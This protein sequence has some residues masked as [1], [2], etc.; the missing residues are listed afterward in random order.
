M[1][2]LCFEGCRLRV[3]ITYEYAG[4]SG[5]PHL[6][7]ICSTET[8]FYGVYCSLP[9]IYEY[10]LAFMP[11]LRTFYSNKEKSSAWASSLRVWMNNLA[12]LT[13][14]GNFRQLLVHFCLSCF[15]FK[16]RWFFEIFQLCAITFGKLI[17][18]LNII[19]KP[20]DWGSVG[21]V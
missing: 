5:F 16:N 19:T 6:L 14:W 2:C 15:H 17:M 8:C 20:V 4:M 13:D 18:A 9:I 7:L 11:L 12:S 10:L 1:N 21:L 3:I